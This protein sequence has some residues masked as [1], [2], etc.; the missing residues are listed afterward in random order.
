[1][2]K[3]F[4]AVIA[5]AMSANMMAQEQEETK[6]GRRPLNTEE[7]AQKRTEQMVKAYGLSDEQAAKLLELNK[8]QK[9]Q[10][11]HRMGQMGSR[12]HR[13]DGKM[14]PMGKLKADKDSF[15]LGERPQM[16]RHE[17]M[18]KQREEYDN[19]LKE[20]LT[21]EQYAAYKADQ[22]KRMKEHPADRRPPKRAE[23][24]QE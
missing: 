19:A 8:S 7:M 9:M 20:I 17:G 2:K 10:M 12:A 22:E 18:R 3:L 15:K 21:E 24:Q 6:Q 16:M 5:I 13:P 23:Q 4:L 1:M 14:R 11:R